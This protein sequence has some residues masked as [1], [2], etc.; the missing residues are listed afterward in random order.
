MFDFDKF[1]SVVR[2]V[3]T[4]IKYPAPQPGKYDEKDLMR[5]ISDLIEES[6]PNDM[7]AIPVG[8]LLGVQYEDL[9]PED[10]GSTIIVSTRGGD[11]FLVFVVRAE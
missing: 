11:R 1:F 9:T 5:D 3:V 2:T 7:S 4:R 10:V 8:N 6:N